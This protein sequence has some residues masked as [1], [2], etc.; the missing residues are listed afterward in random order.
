[1]THNRNQMDS[2][3]ERFLQVKLRLL[4][5]KHVQGFVRDGG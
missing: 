5:L 2:V 4:V 3:Q 1:M